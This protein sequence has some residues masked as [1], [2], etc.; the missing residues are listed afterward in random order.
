MPWLAS[1]RHPHP[2][3]VVR[4][5]ER[6]SP[7]TDPRPS[8]AGRPRLQDSRLQ[9]PRDHGQ[10]LLEPDSCGP[11]GLV[12]FNQSLFS[13]YRF[14]VLDFEYSEFRAE[15]RHRLCGQNSGPIVLT[16]HQPDFIHAGVWAKNV[17]ASAA[18]R[19]TGGTAL[20]L[21]VDSDAPSAT[22]WTVPK[23]LADRT[24]P[25]NT[26]YEPFRRGVAFEGWPVWDEPARQRLESGIRE[27]MGVRYTGSMMPAFFRALGDWNGAGD[28]VDQMMAARRGIETEL[29]IGVREHRISRVWVGP[30]FADLLLRAGEFLESHNA[31]L[32]DYRRAYRVRGADRPIADLEQAGGRIEV[33]VWTYVPG[34]RRRRL[35][36][37]SAGDRVALFADERKLGEIGMGDAGRWDRMADALSHFE[38]W[39]FRPRALSLTLWARLFL[40]DVFI[41]GIGGAKYDRVTDDIIRR[42]YGFEPPAMGCVS[43]TLMLDEPAGNDFSE[44][45]S[46][47]RYRLRDIRYNPQRYLDQAG[48]AEVVR[49]RAE[50][51]RESDRLRIDDPR[52]HGDRRKAFERIRAINDRM[53]SSHP[54]VLADLENDWRSARRIELESRDARWRE[55]FFGFHERSRLIEL[56]DRIVAAVE[57]A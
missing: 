57:A 16:G 10:I 47:A 38:G 3:S 41:H 7:V 29:D 35:F 5:A 9:V 11:A 20:N 2:G 34:Q 21:V 31:A 27:L 8:T 36:V 12:E 23:Q 28:G 37:Q 26:T 22:A 6:A 25:T 44:R 56:R 49:A 48:T 13:T 17:A 19:M 1:A 43:A 39:V 32:A 33:P 55:Y 15:L 53:L 24:V 18:A 52:N 54:S 30:W 14:A 4:E 46:R 45:E 40:G 42:Y 50:A 51:I